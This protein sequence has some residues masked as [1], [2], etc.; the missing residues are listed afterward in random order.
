MQFPNFPEP[1]GVPPFLPPGGVLPVQRNSKSSTEAN[2]KEIER[3][4]G[5]ITSGARMLLV[6]RGLP[7][8]GKSTLAK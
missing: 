2:E 8:S 1:R 7:G 5:K 6:L 4:K 3:I